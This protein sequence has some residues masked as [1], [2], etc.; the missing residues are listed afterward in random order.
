[1]VLRNVFLLC[2][3]LPVGGL[4]VGTAASAAP[5]GAIG[6][7]G[8]GHWACELPGDAL[9]PP[10][11][12]PGDDFLTVPDSNY[13]G[14]NGRRGAYLLLG[15]RLAMTSGP[16]AGQHYLKVGS[17]TI[18]RLGADGQRE[19]LRCVRLGAA[20]DTGLGTGPD[21]GPDSGPNPTGG[22]QAQP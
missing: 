10:T 21:S 2:C 19:P 17:S 4:F 15:D 6:T 5:G 20:R 9:Q 8:Q 13:I 18:I 12:Q 1:M 11:R 7:L 16:F 22:P 3:A 14:P